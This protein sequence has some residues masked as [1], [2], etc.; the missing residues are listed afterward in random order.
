MRV[1]MNRKFL[2][3]TLIDLDMNQLLTGKFKVFMLDSTLKYFDIKFFNT[4]HEMID[5]SLN[6]FN[7]LFIR[8]KSL[9]KQ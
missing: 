2:M 8:R 3:Q 6:N 5:H 1:S 9:K 4:K 7:Y